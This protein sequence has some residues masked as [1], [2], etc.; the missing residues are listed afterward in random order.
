[1]FDVTHNRYRVMQLTLRTGQSKVDAKLLTEYI[2][3][4]FGIFF[5]I[6][7]YVI[8]LYAMRGHGNRDLYL[9]L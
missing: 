6:G 4:R 7:G 8:C 3:H 5:M 1:M 2:Q 9:S